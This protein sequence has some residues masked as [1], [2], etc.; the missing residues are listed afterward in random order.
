MSRRGTRPVTTLFYRR[1]DSVY[2]LGLVGP[3][4]DGGVS[5]IERERGLLDEKTVEY[6]VTTYLI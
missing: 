4:N 6:R 3:P 1:I 2:S 5:G